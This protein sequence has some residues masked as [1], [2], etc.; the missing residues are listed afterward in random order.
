MVKILKKVIEAQ[1]VT[2]DD[3]YTTGEM[4]RKRLVAWLKRLIKR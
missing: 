1:S 2:T 3:A 4:Y